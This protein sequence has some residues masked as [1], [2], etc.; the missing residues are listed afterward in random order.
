MMFA[1]LW[2]S[3]HGNPYDGHTLKEAI[4]QYVEDMGIKPK[5]IYVDKGYRGHDPSLKLNVFKSG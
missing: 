1:Y 2:K 5:R 3:L 4:D